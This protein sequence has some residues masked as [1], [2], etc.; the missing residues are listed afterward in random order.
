MN[1]EQTI[2][3]EKLLNNTVFCLYDMERQKMSV[4]LVCGR[5]KTETVR[6]TYYFILHT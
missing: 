6:S 4:S 2:A 1:N 3:I 5:L